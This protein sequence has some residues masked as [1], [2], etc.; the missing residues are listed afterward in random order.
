[1]SS[2]IAIVGMACCYPDARNPRELWE[3]VLAQRRAFRRIPAERLR[4]EDYFSDDSSVP[5]SIYSTQAA[6]IEGYEFDRVRFRVPGSTFRGVD[7]VHWLALDIADQALKDAGFADGDGL[8]RES[9]G[10]LVGNTLTGEFS[11]AATL[12][13]RW[14]YVRR[15]L[16]SQLSE[17]GWEESRRTEFLTHLEEK[18]KAPFAEVGEET[19]AGALS[20]TIAG[21]ICNF[22]NFG[23][24]GFTVDG[25]CSS[26]LLS[27]AKA[28]SA[29]E[30][31]ELD[32]V[33]AGG[34]DLSLDPF[35]LVGFAKAGALAHGEMLVYDRESSGFLPGEGCGFVVLMRLADAITQE[36][37]IYAVIR[38]WGISSDGGGGITRPEMRGQMLALDRAY[39]R[40]GHEFDSVALIE[41]HGTGTPVGDEVELKALSAA[42]KPANGKSPAAIGSV[43]AN[44]GH[45]KAAAGIAG[46]IKATLSVHHHVLPP[47]TGVGKPRPEVEGDDS[48]LRVL[49]EA[50]PWP[51][52]LPVRAGVNSFGFGGINVHVTLEDH[53]ERAG[54]RW[55]ANKKAAT[56]YPQDAELFLLDAAS[57]AELAMKVAHIAKLAPNLCY[58]EMIDL[59]ATLADQV[60]D[61]A[62]RL[63]IIAGT[64]RQ[65]AD[66]LNKAGLLFCDRRTCL[67]TA[68]GLFI[69]Q[70]I[71]QPRV[72]VL[73]PGQA[74]PVRLQAGIHG[75]FKEVAAVYR[76]ASFAI[77]KNDNA[78]E[79][80]Q[81]AI[82][83]A[84]LAG[85]RLLEKFG[86]PISIAVGHSLGELAAYCWAGAVDE[87][88]LLQLVRLRGRVM[89]R[90]GEP[91]GAMANIGASAAEIESIL[92]DDRAVV[93]CFNAARQT[94]VSGEAGALAETVSRAQNRGW[95]AVLLS[96]AD[97]FHSPLMRPAAKPFREGL[98][99]F[100]L[101]PLC[102]KVISTI[103]GAPLEGEIARHLLIE[104]LTSPVKFLQAMSIAKGEADLFIE[105][106]PGN[107]LANLSKNIVDVPALSLDIAGTS[108]VGLFNALGAAW[109]LGAQIHVK[110]LFANRFARPYDLTR[111]PRFFASPCESAPE[112][113]SNEMRA[114]LKSRGKPVDEP[115]SS[116]SDI[117]SKRPRS[118]NLTSGNIT[119]LIRNLLVRRAELPSESIT[120][121]SRL[122]RDL[123]L[124]S[125]VVGEIVASAARE[126]GIKPPGNL[127]SFADSSVQELAQRLERL[128]DATDTVVAEE[129]VP[130][131]IDDWCRAFTVDWVPR[132][133]PDRLHLASTPGRWSLLGSADLD[134]S[135]AF[136][137]A[138]LPGSGVVVRMSS[139]PPEEQF[140]MLLAGA[141]SAIKINH[142]QKYFV[143]LG[144]VALTAGFARTVNL[145]HPEIHARVIEISPNSDVLHILRAEL[146]NSPAYVTAR[147]EAGGRYEPRFKLL[148]TV[149]GSEPPIKR[150]DVV[151]VSGGAKGIV[152]ECAQAWAKETGAR[153]ILLGRSSK[154]DSAVTNRL[155][156][157]RALGSEADYFQADVTDAQTV[158][159][160][161]T[162]VEQI[163]GP[164]TGIIHGAGNNQPTLVRDL[165]EAKLA[166]TIAPKI[167]GFHNLVAAVD[168]KQLRSLITFG[169]VIGR[170]GLRGEADYALA[171]AALSALTE[172]F[173]GKHPNCRCLSFE[174]SVWS[175]VGMAERLGR[176]ESLRE[177]GV[178]AIAPQEGAR[179]FRRLTNQILPA[180]SVV[181][182]GRLG[183]NPPIPIDD[184]PL[185]LLRFLE[186]PRV[187]YPGVE[188]VTEAEVSTASDPYLLDHVFHGQPLLPA[189]IGLEA[190]VQVATAVSAETRLP[191]IEDVR[192]EHPI[193]VE[194]G[195][196]VTL[197]IAALVR[198][199]GKVDVAIRSSQTAFQMDHFRC[200]C[201][202]RDQSVNHK[203]IF[204]VSHSAI[205][206]FD[207][208]RDLY[209]SL[210]FH[211]P[212]FQRL[213]KYRQ[214]SSRASS[215][216]ISPVAHQ[217]WF[218]SYHP[219]TMT[220]GDAAARDAALHSIQACVPDSLLLPLGV[221]QISVCQLRGDESFVANA[222]ERWHDGN[223]YCYDIELR[224]YRDNIREVWKGLR[225][226]KIEEAKK[227][228]L[229]EPLVAANLEWQIRKAAPSSRISAAFERD[230]TMERRRRS[231]L[232]IQR[233][234]NSTQRVRWQADGK[235]EVDDSFFVSS[236]HSDGLTLAVS[237]TEEVGC[238][239]ESVCAR[240]E[241]MWR[242]LL[243]LD[244][245]LLAKTI[246]QQAQED[247]HTAATRVWTA[248]ESMV[249]AGALQDELLLLCSSIAAHQDTVCLTIRGAFII[250]SAIHFRGDPSTYIAAVLARNR[251]CIST[252]TGTALDLKIP[253]L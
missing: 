68:E 215:A 175:N 195:T 130:A 67:N 150:G 11:R 87:T 50:Q 52:N 5:D 237:A 118:T 100:E 54:D 21:R 224:D 90:D 168:P 125:I 126:L 137:K 197:R 13:L 211:G 174:S 200:S 218:S 210:L 136:S 177:T 122:L 92:R 135:T 88:L 95:T 196:K 56:T 244:R 78:T 70:N 121:T 249:K 44:F 182:T 206:S 245:W 247:I 127:L 169:S 225:F 1:M 89:S 238:D 205:Q 253:T 85:I 213:A 235:P 76:E 251:V 242:D 138:A 190:M 170:I 152:A 9:T 159:A 193:A 114:E 223:T 220:L 233:A 226:R 183:A 115:E 42:R 141:Q 199:S 37:Q 241:E 172:E 6:V 51:A 36:R 48:N 153:L 176:V 43:K 8:P 81:L 32:A 236:A 161:V 188:L 116:R 191:I 202:F 164:V 93:A 124:N 46:L 184:Q 180:T 158:N 234:L 33:L 129:T 221:D 167:K 160:A 232:A 187:H 80:A 61:G 99:G 82:I 71:G 49:R 228:E 102:K 19:L 144:P 128:R 84:E 111:Q 35:E 16:A 69:C 229:S 109:A 94:V 24:G 7:L 72:G 240:S 64:P 165:D 108:L 250:T 3:N 154:E 201:I 230:K 166:V 149:P 47:A 189:V 106:G 198:E 4:L 107:V 246:V 133:L 132:S 17:T 119:G 103:T 104:Q 77:D 96:A 163:F 73:F 231:E 26:S 148:T 110:E 134:F 179:W 25:A 227:T 2:G 101:R 31:G 204:P 120:D 58:S 79:T 15:I 40:A 113:S 178:A 66:K 146:S 162:K 207:L 147:Y 171:N 239:L 38:G 41:G 243:G 117:R 123:H 18:Y 156:D 139:A 10:V 57:P 209:E 55:S 143:I 142:A 212:R 131:G 203:S 28:C 98:A 30:D 62:A 22:F 151:L 23:G 194:T 155:A 214:L 86:L 59:S 252:S 20:N 145:E 216:E 248:M 181:L 219:G 39:R 63:S 186:R 192:F 45:T 75:R 12:R 185:P 173:A 208:A 97:A 60:R 27:V 53:S 65:L 157:M 91:R 14:P 83:T 74:S 222:S 34:V 217:T 105:C 112:F 29:L 140:N